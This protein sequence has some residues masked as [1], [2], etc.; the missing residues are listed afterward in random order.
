MM[1]I[2]WLVVCLVIAVPLIRNPQKV[3]ERPACKIKNPTVIRVL[4][5]LVLV[6]AIGSIALRF[7][8]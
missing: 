7:A 5:I 8:V 4:G 6:I 1:D 3:T 2:L